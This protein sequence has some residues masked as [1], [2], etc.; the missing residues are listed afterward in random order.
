MIRNVS[1]LR[2]SF[3][4]AAV[5]VL[6]CEPA[7]VG[8]SACLGLADR[9]MGITAGE[10]APCADELIASLESLRLNLSPLVS[11]ESSAY[12]AAE[13]DYSRLRHLIAE[14]GVMRDYRSVTGAEV[15]RWPEGTVR[16]F[17]RAVFG[18][19]VQYGSALNAAR[20][21]LHEGA[22]GNFDQASDLHDEAKKLH[23]QMR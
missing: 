5:L 21:G 16:A 11:E 18:A 20:R 14:T 23:R 10:Y 1:C 9:K 22:R 3:W 17:N 13:R 8:G 15:Q 7:Q 4:L 6:G 12:E 2:R 19:S